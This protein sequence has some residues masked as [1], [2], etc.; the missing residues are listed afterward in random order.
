MEKIDGFPMESSAMGMKT[1]V[2]KVEP[3]TTPASEFAPP[4]GFTAVDMKEM[5]GK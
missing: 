2:K 4:A 1:I 5:G 3:R